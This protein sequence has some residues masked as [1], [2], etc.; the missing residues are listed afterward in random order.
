MWIQKLNQKPVPLI[1]ATWLP[2]CQNRHRSHEGWTLAET[3]ELPAH[4]VFLILPLIEAIWSQN[5]VKITFFTLFNTWNGKS[6]KNY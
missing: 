1:A 6:L 2:D 3:Q 5:D 4:D